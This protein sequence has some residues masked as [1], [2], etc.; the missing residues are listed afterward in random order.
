MYDNIEEFL[1]TQGDLMPIRYSYSDI[2]KITKNFKD[3]LGQGG[4]DSIYKG[5]LR[6]GRLA[7]IKLLGNSKSNGQDFINEVGTIRTIHH[8]NV[9]KLIDFCVQGSKH[10]LVYDFMPNG[11]LDKYLFSSEVN[12][13]I[14]TEKMYEISLGVAHGIE[15]LHRVFRFRPIS[16]DIEAKVPCQGLELGH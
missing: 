1:Q 11:S 8:F 4:Y 2:K 9:V 5:R 15:Y 13:S 12:N 6:S 7:A 16:L 14:S 3:K 10:A